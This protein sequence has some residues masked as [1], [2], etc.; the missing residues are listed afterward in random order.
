[1]RPSSLTSSAAP[2]STASSTSSRRRRRTRD[3]VLARPLDL[4]PSRRRVDAVGDA[5]ARRRAGMLRRTRPSS[6]RIDLVGLEVDDRV[7]VEVEGA[8]VGKQHLDAAVCVRSRSP[9][10]SGIDA[11]RGL[12]RP[13]RSSDAAPSTTETCAGESP[14]RRSWTRLRTSGSSGERHAD[15]G[16]HESQA[17]HRQP[18]ER[19]HRTARTREPGS[20]RGRLARASIAPTYGEINRRYLTSMRS[21]FILSI[22]IKLRAAQA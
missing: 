9:A 1:M 4:R 21:D 8:A 5:R 16:R 22:V 7:G 14:R 2:R 20:P 12:D 19:H 15:R 10:S 11:R 18:R 17:G 13:S 3:A 6:S